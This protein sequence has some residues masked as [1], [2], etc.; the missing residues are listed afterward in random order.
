MGF[1][2]P[3]APAAAATTRASPRSSRIPHG[4]CSTPNEQD[5]LT[6]QLIQGLDQPGHRAVVCPRLP[7]DLEDPVENLRRG[8]GF[9][10][11]ERILDSAA[12]GVL[13]DDSVGVI[14]PRSP[15]WLAGQRV[16]LL[17]RRAGH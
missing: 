2:I 14:P 15:R 8:D 11:V 5:L 17:L 1:A 10:E 12:L 9:R 6:D 7:R 16:P 13:E 3:A 4:P